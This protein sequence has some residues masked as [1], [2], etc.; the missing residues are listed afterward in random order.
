[1]SEDA[2]V[3]SVNHLR[4]EQ[5]KVTD[6]LVSAFELDHVSDLL[7]FHMD[8]WSVSVTL[9]VDKSKNVVSVFP[10]V[11]LRKPSVLLLATPLSIS[12]ETCLGLSGQKQ[13]PPA[14]KMAGSI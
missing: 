3:C 5:F 6:V 7:Q 14:R 9:C 4:L 13:R 10:S 8:E 2:N 11:L 1:M 12:M